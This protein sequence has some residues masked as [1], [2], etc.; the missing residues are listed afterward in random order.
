MAGVPTFFFSHARQD[1]ELSRN[2]YLDKF[3]EDLEARVASLAGIDLSRVRIGTIDRKAIVQGASWDATLSQGL[4]SNKAFVSVFTPL[5]FTRPSCGKELFVFLMR[6]RGLGVDSNGALTGV[7]NVLPIRWEIKEAYYN[8]TE[9]DSIIPAF[10]SLIHDRPAHSG[11]NST[12]SDAVKFY[13]EKGMQRCV[14]FEPHYSELLDSF[15]LRIRSL[16]DLPEASGVSF[17]T[18]QDAFTYDWKSHF[19]NAGTATVSAAPVVSSQAVS[20]KPLSSVVAFYVTHRSFTPDRTLVDF[21]DQLVAEPL[22][23]GTSSTDP[24]F[25]ALLTDVRAAGIAEGLHVFHA[26]AEPAVPV[27]A[28]PLL[29]RLISLS[30]N[31]MLSFV[32]VDSNVWPGSTNDAAVAI[33]EI[34][35]S[36]D[37]TGLVLVS[38]VGARG[39]DLDS[40]TKSRGLP[41]RLVVLPQS[42]DARISVL[43]RAFIDTRGRVL[44][45]SVESSPGAERVPLLKGVGTSF[46][47]GEGKDHR[48]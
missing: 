7:E 10:L 20:L 39:F 2:N 45:G 37:W 19:A 46:T 17:A 1:R 31:R 26:A 34:V 32:I 43:Q 42:S 3:F 36:P 30:K 28:K 12:L 25:A 44:S 13:Y 47:N 41:P 15:A 29:D 4:G 6:S 16:T 48:S 9:S 33:E 35:R 38:A 8:N 24:G 18:A 14:A 23:G 40:L 5:Y 22:H 21:A 11:G 27:T